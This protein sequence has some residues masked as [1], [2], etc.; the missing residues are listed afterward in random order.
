M[1]GDMTPMGSPHPSR[2]VR[3]TLGQ[4]PSSQHPTEATQSGGWKLQYSLCAC[5]RACACVRA[6][7]CM[8][9][10]SLLLIFLFEIVILSLPQLDFFTRLVLNSFLE[11]SN[12]SSSHYDMA[13]LVSTMTC[14]L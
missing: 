5:M 14:Q 11:I 12:L 4:G 6:R 2:P 13:A 9:L 1:M 7:V 10:Y 3:S 8:L